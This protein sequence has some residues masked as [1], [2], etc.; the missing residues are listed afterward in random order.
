MDSTFQSVLHIPPRQLECVTRE[1][2]GTIINGQIAVNATPYQ[3]LE[4]CSLQE[5]IIRAARAGGARSDE[6][7]LPL[8]PSSLRVHV[9]ASEVLVHVGR[10]GHEV[11]FTWPHPIE[12]GDLADVPM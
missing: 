8:S 4:L 1:R 7:M 12:P 6:V 3:P 11:R 5:A 2:N 10:T 9:Q